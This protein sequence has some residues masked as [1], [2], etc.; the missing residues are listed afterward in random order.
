MP[1]PTL[2]GVFAHPDD[3]TFGPGATLA[4]YASEGADVHIC[5]ATDGAAGTYNPALLQA[6][7]YDTLAGLRGAELQCAAQTLGVT[8]HRLDYRD[9]GMGGTADNENPACLVPGRSA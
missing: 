1:T 2:L 9:S 8:L 3:E 6:S 7:D 5:I 4:K